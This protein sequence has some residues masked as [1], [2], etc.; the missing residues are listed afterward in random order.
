[1]AVFTHSEP[2]PV[3]HGWSLGTSFLGRAFQAIVDA[4]MAKAE[5]EVQAYIA[6]M[7]PKARKEFDL[8][9]ALIGKNGIYAWPY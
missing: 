4:R 1:M 5:R 7:E 8:D 9:K 6:T 3:M 2:Q